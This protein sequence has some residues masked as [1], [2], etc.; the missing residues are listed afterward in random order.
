MSRNA[1]LA[2]SAF[3][4]C[5]TQSRWTSGE[6][7]SKRVAFILGTTAGCSSTDT[8]YARNF[9]LDR[10]PDP[11]FFKASI[12]QNPAMILK[13]FSGLANADIYVI[14]NAC[15]SASDAIGLGAQFL[16]NDI[17]D[18]VFAGG[19]DEI[20]FQT[21][22]GFA[23]LQLV[24]PDYQ[25]RPFDKNRSGLLLTVWRYAHTRR[26]LRAES[27]GTRARVEKDA[28]DDRGCQEGP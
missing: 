4:E 28:A 18:V 3:E 6:L 19:S 26:L 15:T 20:L 8:D 10:S 24:S 2:L 27:G 22:Y 13:K 1:L 25:C 12:R 9:V 5:L 17:Y 16:E 11:E 23:S 7:Q 21:F 14:N